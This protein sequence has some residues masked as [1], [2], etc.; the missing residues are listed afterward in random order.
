MLESRL[1]SGSLKVHS[2]KK[3]LLNR[4]SLDDD[5]EPSWSSF[6]SRF[7]LSYTLS[8][9]VCNSLGGWSVSCRHC[10]CNS[11]NIDWMVFV[12]YNARQTYHAC[13]GLGISQVNTSCVTE[14]ITVVVHI[15]C[16][17]VWIFIYDGYQLVNFWKFLILNWYVTMMYDNKL[18]GLFPLIWYNMIHTVMKL[19]L[20]LLCKDKLV[21]C[22][23]MLWIGGWYDMMRCDLIRHYLIWHGLIRH[24]LIRHDMI[25][26]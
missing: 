14:L 10:V 21:T 26:Q 4:R 9:Q 24:D 16:V 20:L 7:S 5:H 6:V 17:D 19:M 25:W 1:D 18:D 12:L 8:K 23:I 22:A 11:L 3:N 15:G 2:P 13:T